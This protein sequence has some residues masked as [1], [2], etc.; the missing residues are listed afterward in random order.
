MDTELLDLHDELRRVLAGADWTD[1]E[2]RRNLIDISIWVR[3]VD[4][5]IEREAWEI[6]ASL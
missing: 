3:D 5:R 6:V 4:D 2:G 1:D